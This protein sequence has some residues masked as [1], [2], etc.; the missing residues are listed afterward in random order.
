MSR[1]L[2]ECFVMCFD[3]LIIWQ[4]LN[5]LCFHATIKA[6][7]VWY[8]NKFQ[9]CKMISCWYLIKASRHKYLPSNKKMFHY[10][11]SSRFTSI[12]CSWL[13]VLRILIWLIL[14]AFF[15]CANK[16][17]VFFCH[18]PNPRWH[19]WIWILHSLESDIEHGEQH[20]SIEKF[21]SDFE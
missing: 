21:V 6:A 20:F 11:S 3:W 7:L 9:H 15:L 12:T 2:M 8:L 14:F 4:S 10:E 13:W 17:L 1:R 5:T 16:S 18:R 19:E